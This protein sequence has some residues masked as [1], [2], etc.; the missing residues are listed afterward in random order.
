SICPRRRTRGT[1]ETRRSTRSSCRH[2]SRAFRRTSARRSRRRL[3]RAA[4]A[5]SR[6]VVPAGAVAEEAVAVGDAYPYLLVTGCW[7][8]RL[9]RCVH[10][11]EVAGSNPAQPTESRDGPRV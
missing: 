1:S 11:A 8:S 10:I 3:A 4:A 6:A 5:D 7:L 9:E 2:P